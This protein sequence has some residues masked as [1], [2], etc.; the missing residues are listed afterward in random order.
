M[1]VFQGIINTMGLAIYVPLEQNGFAVTAIYFSVTK[2]QN[3]CQN[4][5]SIF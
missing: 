5:M 2:Y 4:M 1:F 3:M